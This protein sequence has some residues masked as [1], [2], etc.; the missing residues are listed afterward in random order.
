MGNRNKRK[1]DVGASPKTTCARRLAE[2]VLSQAVF[3]PEMRRTIGIYSFNGRK[4]VTNNPCETV[5]EN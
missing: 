1:G 4:I 5:L 3:S 2:E